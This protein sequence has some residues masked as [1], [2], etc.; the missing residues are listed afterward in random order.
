MKEKGH[1]DAEMRTLMAPESSVSEL[2]R[3]RPED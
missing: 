1:F 3:P 2:S